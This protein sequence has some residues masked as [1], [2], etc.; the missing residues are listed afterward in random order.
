MIIYRFVG[1]VPFFIANL[2]P[3]I[4]NIKSSNYF[5]G[6]IIGILP[7]VFLFVSLGSGFSEAIYN[8]NN[9]PSVTDLM[10]EPGIYL[11]IIGFIFILIVSFFLRKK[12]FKI[13]E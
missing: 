6:T 3:V 8:Y 5:I 9:Y 1:L 7:A 13:N 12:F 10:K 2:I 11:P 4:F